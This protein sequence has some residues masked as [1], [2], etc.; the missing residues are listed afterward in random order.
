MEKKGK[1]TSI[2]FYTCVNAQT[3]WENCSSLV[4]DVDFKNGGWEDIMF[5]RH[6]PLK[7]KDQLLN[8]SFNHFS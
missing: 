7:G 1:P 5:S 4:E 3:I 2:I 8:R 6:E